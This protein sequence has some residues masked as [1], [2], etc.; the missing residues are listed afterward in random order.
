[1]YSLN[2]SGTA[3]LPPFNKR[4]PSLRSRVVSPLSQ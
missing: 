4:P 2:H 3:L 1:M